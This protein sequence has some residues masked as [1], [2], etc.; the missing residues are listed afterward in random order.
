MRGQS[1]SVNCQRWCDVNVQARRQVIRTGSPHRQAADQSAETAGGEGE[2][3]TVEELSHFVHRQWE[4]S[5]P[6][7]CRSH[8]LDGQV[9]ENARLRDVPECEEILDRLLMPGGS[10]RVAGITWTGL[11]AAPVHERR[12]AGKWRKAFAVAP[13]AE[14]RVSPGAEV[15]ASPLCSALRSACRLRKS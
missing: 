6:T 12:R 9:I 10:A 7:T 8:L 14:M 11:P 4:R 1:Q 5:T 3:S 2:G 13:C 15:V